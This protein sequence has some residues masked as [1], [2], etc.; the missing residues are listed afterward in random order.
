MFVR[1]VFAAA[2]LILL[3]G[4][5]STPL[6]PREY[7]D[8]QTTATITVAAQPLI[9]VAQNA[10]PLTRE[11][12]RQRDYVELYG[13]D[14]NR[15][16]SHRQYIALLQWMTAESAAAAPAL[17]LS[18]SGETLKLQATAEDPKSLGIAQ[19]LSQSYSAS[20]RWWYYPTDAATLK[21]IARASE[22][23]VTLDTSAGRASYEMFSDGRAQLAE[24][25][26]VLP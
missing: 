15:M 13:I 19:P 17:E 18:L 21:R 10:A 6:T 23:F 8:E 20:S 3:S 2:A 5:V 11:N 26:A 1:H 24:L 16:G 12:D 4:C 14:V 9:F 7:L 25:T 22:L